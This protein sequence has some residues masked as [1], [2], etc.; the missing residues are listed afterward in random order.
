M[1]GTDNYMKKL[2][3]C[4]IWLIVSVYAIRT[5][6][7]HRLWLKWRIILQ[8][9]YFSLRYL[10][11]LLQNDT[12]DFLLTVFLCL[13]ILIAVVN[14]LRLIGI[15][16][17]LSRSGPVQAGERGGNAPVK[18]GKENSK[19]AAVKIGKENS[20][21][22]AA[23]TGTDSGR[24]TAARTGTGGGRATATRTGTGSGRATAAK[25]GF[26]RDNRYTS[27]YEEKELSYMRL[28]AKERYMQQIEG[29]LRDGLVTKEEYNE[30]RRNYEKMEERMKH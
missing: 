29:F 22:A 26:F 24:A 19:S 7:D 15:F 9:R 2:S 11:F 6:W 21:S 20:K 13:L 5:F 12:E 10:Q 30:L 4:L 8:N 25:T 27:V 28:S 18:T 3:R 14:L 1:K 17:A 23:K 16:K